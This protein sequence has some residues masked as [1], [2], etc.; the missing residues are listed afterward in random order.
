M[1]RK[2]NTKAER[3]L[4]GAL[5][6]L[7]W[8]ELEAVSRYL[9]ASAFC[10]K[11]YA[12]LSEMFEGFAHE[13]AENFKVMESACR[14]ISA[15]GVRS[16]RAGAGSSPFRNATECVES[17]ARLERDGRLEYERVY[18]LDESG[19]LDADVQK[20]LRAFGKRLSILENIMRT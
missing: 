12:E 2:G 11:E 17:L 8:R 13:H 10:A 3:A 1:R 20:I 6:V 18:I 5:G 9:S 14:D 19:R 4:S 15:M 7:R 16:V